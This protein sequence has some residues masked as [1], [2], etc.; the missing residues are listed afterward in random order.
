M[1]NLNRSAVVLSASVLLS[2]AW[3]ATPAT[4]QMRGEVGI[5][6]GETPELV[7]IEDLEGNPVS[8]ADFAGEKPV[9][10]EFWAYWCE[11]CA[12]LHPRLVEAYDKYRDR[13]EFV[14]VGVGV[15]QSPRRMKRHLAKLTPKVEWNT[16]FDKRGQAVRSFLAPA[17]SYVAIIGTDGR[18]VYTGIGPDQD[19]EAAILKALDETD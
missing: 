12:A 18:V 17:T 6:L 8:L 4:A 13:I 15:A 19:I 1:H 7:E 16:L 5:A 14:A 9:L 3:L 2:A 11:N 10:F